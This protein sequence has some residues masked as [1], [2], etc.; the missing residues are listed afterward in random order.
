MTKAARLVAALAVLVSGVAVSGV[1]VSDVA[2][3]TPAVVGAAPADLV[4]QVT[5]AARDRVAG[6]AAS[7]WPDA[8]VRVPLTPCH[9]FNSYGT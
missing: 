6:E 3:A 9:T 8:E 2:M 7:Q 1:A 4:A 5:E